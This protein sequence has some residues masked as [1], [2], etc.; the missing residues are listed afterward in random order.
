MSRK[1]VDKSEK[2]QWWTKGITTV[3]VG[4]RLALVPY[5]ESHLAIPHRVNVTLDPGPSFGAGDHPS[6]IM[7]LEL[8]EGVLNRSTEPKEKPS[9]LDVG[10]GTGVLAI[11]AKSLGAGLTVALD[12][13]L[14]SVFSVA[15]RNMQLNKGKWHS[16][17][18]GTI[19][20][21]AG[22]V[23]SVSK[24]FG[25]VV[26]NLAAPLLLRIRAEL[27]EVADKYLILSGIA[28][29]MSEQVLLEYTCRPFQCLARKQAEGWHAML[30]ARG[31]DIL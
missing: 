1:R 28:E 26:A 18:A 5:W 10:T 27:T 29:E 16:T 12:I 2:R 6:T 7:A 14:V 13:D 20:L 21:Y 31:Q 23:A 9:V 15:R 25:L 11:A 30:F 22:D 19:H 3:E 8:L 24:P 17:D 4:E